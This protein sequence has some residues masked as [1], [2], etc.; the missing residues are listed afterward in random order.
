MN[1]MNKPEPSGYEN[2]PDEHFLPLPADL[3]ASLFYQFSLDSA[4]EHSWYLTVLDSSSCKNILELGCGN[5]RI[6]EYLQRCGLTLFGIDNSR[7]M[8]DFSSHSRLVPRCQMDMT[9]LGFSRFF[10]AVLLPCNT[11][12]LLRDKEM[13]KQCLLEIRQVLRNQGLLVLHLFVPDRTLLENAGKKLFQFSLSDLPNGTRLIRETIRT[14]DAGT[15]L[16]TLEERYKLR[17]PGDL[18]KPENYLQSFQLAAFPPSQ[19]LEIIEG[20]G[21]SI[22][23][24]QGRFDHSSSHGQQGSTLL[25]V[26]QY[27]EQ[28]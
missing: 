21:F 11:L 2:E 3:Y 4:E 18:S 9:R 7:E 6:C 1:Q 28:A 25:L 16:L 15:Q 26:A 19:W 12:N 13:I 20:S 22:I 14:Y 23:S 5:G 8:L 27:T 24:T 17:R 10:D